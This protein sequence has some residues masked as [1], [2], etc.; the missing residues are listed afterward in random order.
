MRSRCSSYRP[1]RHRLPMGVGSR[2]SY[3]A[4][5]LKYARKP[6]CKSGSTERSERNCYRAI[7]PPAHRSSRGHRASGSNFLY[8][9]L[10]EH[11]LGTHFR[12]GGSRGASRRFLRLGGMIPSPCALW[13]IERLRHRSTTEGLPPAARSRHPSKVIHWEVA[14]R[15]RRGERDAGRSQRGPIPPPRRERMRVRCSAQ[16][17]V[18]SA[19]CT[20]P[21]KPNPDAPLGTG[22][23][24]ESRTA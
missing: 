17:R 13:G 24:V 15:R 11:N 23:P 3:C 8:A 18:L 12:T 1:V 16:A 19:E 9:A 5:V 7:L 2:A 10:F 4:P 14:A 20:A 22:D 6:A 21:S